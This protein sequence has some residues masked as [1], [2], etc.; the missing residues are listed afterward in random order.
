MVCRQLHKYQHAFA[1]LDPSATHINSHTIAMATSWPRC[2]CLCFPP[3]PCHWHTFQV[4]AAA[5]MYTCL[6]TACYAC[7]NLCRDL[8]CTTGQNLVPLVKGPYTHAALPLAACNPTRLIAHDRQCTQPS[9]HQ[10]LVAHS[11]RVSQMPDAH[12]LATGTHACLGF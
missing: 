9:V 2:A 6:H 11:Y 10:P 4:A 8:S 12:S 3:E 5:R 7:N 1:L